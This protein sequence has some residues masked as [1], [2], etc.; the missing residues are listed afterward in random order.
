LVLQRGQS[1]RC[2]VQWASCALR[3]VLRVLERL[4]WLQTRLR[5]VQPWVRL[6]LSAK[7]KAEAQT[8]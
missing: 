2:R 3:L 1:L 7:T 8:Y 5:R 6:S 4:A